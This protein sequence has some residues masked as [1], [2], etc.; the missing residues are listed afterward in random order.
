MA[1]AR[2]LANRAKLARHEAAAGTGAA[3]PSTT[4]RLPLPLLPRLLRAEVA[5]R[6]AFSI[7]TAAV[8]AAAACSGT[9][10]C[11]TGLA[12]RGGSGTCPS[13]ARLSSLRRRIFATTSSAFSRASPLGCM[14]RASFAIS[15]RAVAFGCDGGPRHCW[16]SSLD[17]HVALLPH[18]K[19]AQ[20]GAPR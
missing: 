2:I 19:Q 14:P 7:E 11:A 13:A 8:G 9:A 17:I 10:L 5:E 6:P 15:L 20:Y 3:E 1:L 4:L 18:R 12:G 16:D